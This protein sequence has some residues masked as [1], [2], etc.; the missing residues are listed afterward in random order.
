VRPRRQRA[1]A[2]NSPAKA[3]TYLARLKKKG[4][5]PAR[6][7]ELEGD[8]AAQSGEF[9][10]A[11]AHY[12]VAADS[13]SSSAMKKLAIVQMRAGETS[14]AQGTVTSW[15]SAHPADHD[16]SLLLASILLDSGDSTAAMAQYETILAKREND[17]VALN[18]L[19]WLYFEA[20]DPRA[21]A[22]GRRALQLTPDDPNIADTLGWI[23]AHSD[24]PGAASEAVA[25]LQS[26]SSAR[27]DSP[28]VLYHLAVAQRKAGRMRDAI[29]SAERALEFE[30]FA[31][32]DAARQ[33]AED[34]QTSP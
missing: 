20:A 30:S 31:E 2:A 3:R 26:A 15:L 1:A 10:V 19:A 29:Q 7:N 8:I 34:L 4:I 9:K 13:D 27:P 25:L 16:A 28:S 24:T 33:L 14:Q 18:N 32:R 22:T 5:D 12:Q 21:E 23:L 17:S 11:V 6:A